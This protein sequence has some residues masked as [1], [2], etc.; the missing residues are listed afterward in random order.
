[1]FNSTIIDVAIG[2]IFV[3]LLLSL[4]SSAVHEMIEYWLKRRASD[5]ERGVRELLTAEDGSDP[6]TLVQQFYNHGMI[7]GLFKGTYQNSRIDNWRRHLV[8]TR[9]PSYIP[10]RNFALALMDLVLPGTADQASGATGASPP[11]PPNVQLSAPAIP[12][13]APTD[14]SNPLNELRN[15]IET[16]SVLK[17][18][19]RVK[20]ALRSL[21][22]ASGADANK[23]RENIEN[24]FNNGMDRVSGWYKRRSQI[25]IFLIG[26]VVTIGLNADSVTIAKRLSSDRSL[27]ESLVSAADA[28]AKANASPSPSPPAAVEKPPDS[29]TSPADSCSEQECKD[30]ED[31]PG[32]KLK[33]NQCAIE[34]LGLPIGW[35][36]P[37]ETWPG[38]HF[39]YPREFVSRWYPSVRLHLFGWL[40]TALAI[41]LGAP[42]W[43]DML[44]KVIV[45]R[46]TV[47]PKEKSQDEPSK[48]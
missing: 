35:N 40:L 43:F 9:L 27:R 13:R 44:N 37:G 24:W 26:I 32:C 42:F 16:A 47:K 34:A 38:L 21:V 3:Y 19:E 4:M 2:I 1:M 45:V 30:K 23:A 29:K 8:G 33:K 11:P 15:A 18:N 12:P 28:Y 31:S 17:G 25:F 5:L 14:P 22:D 48:S 10:S 46:S 41:S 6:G 39:W 36:T 7:S 20:K